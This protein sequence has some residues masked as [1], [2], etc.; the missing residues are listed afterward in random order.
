M[1]IK[2]LV[3]GCERVVVDYSGNPAMLFV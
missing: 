3:V 2:I 1:R